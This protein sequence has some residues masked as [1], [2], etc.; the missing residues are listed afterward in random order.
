[1]RQLTRDFQ[2]FLLRGNIVELAVAVVVGAA[3]GTVVKSFVEDVVMPP[4][5]L[6]L[7]R[8]DPTNLFTVLKAGAEA[9][10]PYPTL[11]A[12]KAAGA[13]TINWGLFANNV[14]A[15][16]IVA[17]VVFLALRALTKLQRKPVPIAPDSKPC[18]FCAMPIPL[19]AKRCPHCTSQLAN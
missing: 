6:L 16:L 15:F 8:V 13:V 11:A 4:I 12:A 3:F 10:P 7:G 5:G 2:A 18:P 9:P 1:V 14:L 17:L 19:V